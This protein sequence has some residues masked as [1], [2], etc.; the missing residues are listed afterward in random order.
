MRLMRVILSVLTVGLIFTSSADAENRALKRQL[1]EMRS[2]K[3][4]ALV[5]GNSNYKSSPLKNP[6]NDAGTE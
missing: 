5:I 4:V 2:E 6:V 1:D 3:R